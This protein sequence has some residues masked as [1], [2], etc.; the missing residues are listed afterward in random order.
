MNYKIK[1]KVYEINTTSGK[2][3]GLANII[4]GKTLHYNTA[5]WKTAK[6]AE[7]FAKKRGFELTT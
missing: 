2:M 6:G 7:N 5:I 4:S 3:Y 1:V